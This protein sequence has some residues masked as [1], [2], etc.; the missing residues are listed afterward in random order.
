MKTKGHKHNNQNVTSSNA[1]Y[2]VCVYEK[3]HYTC[4]SFNKIQIPSIYVIEAV[5]ANNVTF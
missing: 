5:H 2:I 4:K 3:G 1:W